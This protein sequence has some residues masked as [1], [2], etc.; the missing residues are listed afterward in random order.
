[1]VNFE[2]CKV[3][4]ENL[5]GGEGEGFRI[6]M[7]GLDGGRINIAACSLGGA[8][9]ALEQALSYVKDR[10]QFGKPIADFQA[11]Q[12]RLADMATEL[13]AARLLVHRAA[14]SLD[15]ASTEAT[16][17][18]ALAKRFATDVGFKDRK[19]TRLNSSH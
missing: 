8:R 16:Q 14:A 19:S 10:R 6:A 11:T 9:A 15:A 17:H 13:D 7:A 5:V 4:A 1:M 18:A 3:P 12:F 2:D